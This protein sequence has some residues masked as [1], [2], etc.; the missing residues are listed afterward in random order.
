MKRYL[1]R[2]LTD[3]KKIVSNFLRN[4][5]RTNI[6]RFCIT[7]KKLL[8]HWMTFFSSTDLHSCK[9]W[10]KSVDL[11]YIKTHPNY[12]ICTASWK[13]NKESQ[14]QY[15]ISCP[16]LSDWEK[17][18][19]QIYACCPESPSSQGGRQ[20]CW[21]WHACLPVHL[22]WHRLKVKKKIDV[23]SLFCDLNIQ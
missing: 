23:D 6:L 12:F 20:P 21:G 15:W 2:S 19:A 4:T 9:I 13:G 14:E 18:H 3:S 22:W 1:E 8:L 7:I 17:G 16:F 10:V 11:L 5:F